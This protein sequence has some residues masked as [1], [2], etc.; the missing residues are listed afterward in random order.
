[1]G[2][3]ITDDDEVSR[4]IIFDRFFNQNIH[5]DALLWQ[6]GA[7]GDDGATHESGVL[8]RIASLSQD[9]H[10]I[11]CRIAAIQNEKRSNP[12]PGPK[13]RYYCGFRTARVGDLPRTG[14]HYSLAISNV[15]EF[16]E[17]AHV[18]FA[19][20][21]SA[22]GKNAR[23]TIRTDVGL[24]LAEQFSAPEPHQ[25]ECDLPDDQHPLQ[26]FGPDCLIAGLKNRWPDLQIRIENNAAR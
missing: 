26:K 23:A 19:L 13:R 7:Q 4:C 5:T 15:E 25:C 20:T 17:K 14:E 6:F 21:I 8:R 1:M 9:V 3:E 16:G 24:A 22:T 2:V 18:D 10:L 12:P 11:G